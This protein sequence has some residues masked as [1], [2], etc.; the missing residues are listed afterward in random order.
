M[1]P[2][3]IH[4]VRDSFSTLAPQADRVADLFYGRLFETAPNLRPLF[5]SDMKIQKGKLMQMLAAG[6]ALLDRPDQLVPVLRDLGHRHQSYGVKDEHYDVVAAALLWTL[7]HGLGDRFDA[8]LR[9]AW[10]TTYQLIAAQMKAGA[11]IKETA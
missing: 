10:T 1:T 2:Q 8:P 11:R 9:D 5:R 4:L 7:E 6:V 3:Q